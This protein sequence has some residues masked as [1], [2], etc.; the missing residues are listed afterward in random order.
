LEKVLIKA[1]FAFNFSQGIKNAGSYAVSKQLKNLLNKF[2]ISVA[3][4][5]FFFF[6][7]L[8]IDKIG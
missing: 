8:M 7:L 1:K 6:F 2:K 3:S 5:Q 4:L